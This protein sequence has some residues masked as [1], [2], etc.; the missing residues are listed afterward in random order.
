MTCEMCEGEGT[1]PCDEFDRD[2]GQAM[3][4]VGLMKCLCRK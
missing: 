2:S 4:G 3:A 1:L